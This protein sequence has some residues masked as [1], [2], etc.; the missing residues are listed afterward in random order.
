[1]KRVLSVALAAVIIAGGV[2][3]YRLPGFGIEAPDSIVLKK[4]ERFSVD[5]YVTIDGDGNDIFVEYL[6]NININQEGTYTLTV[7]AGDKK[8]NV[9]EKR[10][11]V[12]VE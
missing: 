1:M 8:G 5:D 10:V 3:I 11:E 2:Y 7:K 6:D 9:K 12:R 4:G